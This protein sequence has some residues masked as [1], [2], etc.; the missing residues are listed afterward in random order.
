MGSRCTAS[1]P[2][3][4]PSRRSSAAA[5]PS[6]PASRS[7]VQ[8]PTLNQ[9]LADDACMSAAF[10][11]RQPLTLNELV[12]WTACGPE[13]TPPQQHTMTITVICQHRS[14][15]DPHHVTNKERTRH[16]CLPRRSAKRH[17]RHGA[18]LTGALLPTARTP[19]C[20][21]RA[22]R[23]IQSAQQGTPE[24]DRYHEAEAH[25]RSD[26]RWP[27]LHMLPE[28]S[29]HARAGDCALRAPGTAL[30]A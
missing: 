9:S 22:A 1:P 6:G 8:G 12:A 2:A 4:A 25:Q 15:V 29:E 7:Q 17:A 21:V 14:Q 28:S 18:R 23:R 5:V 27:V 20:P 16:S 30:R 26:P 13:R 19:M 3:R 11:P 10:L 24:M